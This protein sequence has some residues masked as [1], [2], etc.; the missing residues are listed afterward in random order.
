[1]PD[2]SDLI[3]NALKRCSGCGKSVIDGGLECQECRAQR[4]LALGDIVREA[5]GWAIVIPVAVFIGVVIT[6]T[7]WP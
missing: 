6:T 1:M 7:I 4:V 3:Q 2:S 5:G